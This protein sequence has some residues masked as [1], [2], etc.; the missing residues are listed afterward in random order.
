[1]KPPL[2]LWWATLDE[3]VTPR[4]SLRHD[5][6]V[7]VAIVGG[8]FTGLWTARELKRRDPQLRIAVLEK[9]VCGFGASGRNGGWASAL[10]PIKND[11]IV[12]RYGIDAFTHQR[13]VLEGAV[14][15]LGEAI[16]DDGID[17]RFVQGGTLT[18]ARSE[19]QAARLRDEVRASRE[20]GLSEDDVRWLE[21]S[22]LYDFGY[23]RGAHGAMYSPHCARINPAR[24]V[25]GLCDVDEKLGVAIFEDTSVTRIVPARRGH[26]PRVLTIGGTVSADYV[27]RATEAF[28]PTFPGER[29]TLAPIYSMMIAT[30]PLS[31]SFW[32]EAGFRDYATFTDDRNLTIY[33]QRTSD[34]RIAF[35]GRGAPYHFGSTVEEQF[36]HDS[37]V[38]SALETTLRELFPTLE[39]SITHRWGGPVGMN[40][41]LSPSVMVDYETGLASAGGYTG[42]G[43]VLSRVC[44]TAIADLL[45]A[46]STETSHTSLPFVQHQGK[47]WELEPLRWL[48]INVG[49]GLATWADHSERRH[50]RQS[51]ASQ[52]LHRLRG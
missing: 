24:L 14:R 39:G 5:L 44:A 11:A 13:R 50:N 3:P 37:K 4:A 19:L 46:P 43:V 7:D 10:F 32:D 21:V 36:D 35:G 51:R 28:T 34:N 48:G 52:W 47:R 25:R 12:S 15:E 8:G 42:D 41:D 9:S 40:R 6:D 38:F 45:T 2:S 17:A 33:G 49:I 16:S 1:V 22:D 20:L 31:A 27:V 29:R 18:F 23:V 30:E 26:R